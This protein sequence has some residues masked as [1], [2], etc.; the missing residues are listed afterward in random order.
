MKIA[1]VTSAKRGRS[2]SLLAELAEDL[3]AEGRRLT[4][5]VKDQ[6]Y[7]GHYANGCD[8]KIRVLPAGPVIRITQN[9]GQGSDACR[10]DPAAITEAAA[11]AEANLMGDTDL[12]I[13]NKFGPE[14]C[15]G[16][17]FCALIA[18]AMEAGIP[19]LLGVSTTCEAVFAAFS[20]GL[21]EALPDDPAEL[22]NWCA[23]VIPDRKTHTPA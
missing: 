1:Y 9:L 4:G 7:A 5:I 18:T 3:Q 12:F 10:L 13:L 20:G 23:K 14:E 21:A 16:R 22:R 19:V 6:S 15:S 17:G 11:R 8:M 2:D